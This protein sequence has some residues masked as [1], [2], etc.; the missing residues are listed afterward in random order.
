MLL[1][2]LKINERERKNIRKGEESTLIDGFFS[3]VLPFA[4]GISLLCC[5]AT[6]PSQFFVTCL[7]ELT[8][9]GSGFEFPKSAKECGSG[10]ICSVPGLL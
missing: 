8:L 2:I 4:Y 7:R 10:A 6:V 1:K 9:A 3:F 5:G